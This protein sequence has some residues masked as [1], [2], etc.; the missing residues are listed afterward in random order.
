MAVGVSGHDSD[1][2][3]GIDAGYTRSTGLRG[4]GC[5]ASK[6]GNYRGG[7]WKGD[8]GTRM[9]V[10]STHE[11]WHTFPAEPLKALDHSIWI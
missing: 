2:D 4:D 11:D 9:D 6:A 7:G 5:R 3:C 8:E 1:G 10:E